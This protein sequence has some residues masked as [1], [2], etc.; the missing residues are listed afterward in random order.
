MKHL[1]HFFTIAVVCFFCQ[2][3]LHAQSIELT[4][5]SGYTFPE[6]FYVENGEVRISGGHT[7]G[8]ML[9]FNISEMYGVELIYT[10]QDAEADVTAFL[11][12]DRNVPVSVN[13]IQAGGIRYF[14]LSS[15][16]SL[17]GGLNL[18]AAGLVPKEKYDQGWL[19]AFGLKGGVKHYFSERIGVRIQANLQMPVQWAGAG[20]FVGTGGSGVSVN[21]FST[22]FQFS[23]TGGLVF[24]LK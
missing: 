18:G 13:Y 2:A 14:P 6:N 10:R 4:P 3:S 20:F 22:I 19:F 23:F 21:S 15:T 7:Y 9:T 11:L 17:L 8:G 5:F 16:T 12:N 24:R 1:F